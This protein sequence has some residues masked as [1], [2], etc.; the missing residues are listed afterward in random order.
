[1]RINHNGVKDEMILLRDSLE[2]LQ[3]NQSEMK[4]TQNQQALKNKEIDLSQRNEIKRHTKSNESP[5]S[6][7]I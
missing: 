3:L 1:M 5:H 2:K 4:Q 6:H 7:H